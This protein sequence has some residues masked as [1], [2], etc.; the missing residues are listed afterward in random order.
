M[1]VTIMKI[2]YVG[3]CLCCAEVPSF[4]HHRYHQYQGQTMAGFG[5][6]CESCHKNASILSSGNF[7]TPTPHDT[8]AFAAQCWARKFL[9]W[10]TL[11]RAVKTPALNAPDGF[12]LAEL[13]WDSYFIGG[14]ACK[15][16]PY[17]CFKAE[18]KPVSKR[19]YDDA[20]LEKL[21][22]LNLY[23]KSVDLTELL[24]ARNVYA[25]LSEVSCHGG[26]ESSCHRSIQ[27][28]FNNAAQKHLKAFAEILAALSITV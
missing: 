24:A 12:Q 27:I 15:S 4:G 9:P 26:N 19:Q 21:A 2:T 1:G 10:S 16:F 20:H 3:V 17:L 11:D 8:V 28:T 6:Y 13:R 22:L 18:K 5:F 23:G 14:K 25:R 7:V